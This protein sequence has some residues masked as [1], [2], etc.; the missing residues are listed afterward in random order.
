MRSLHRLQNT[1][2]ELV[3]AM[4]T[5]WPEV[6]RSS[7]DISDEHLSLART[8]LV[9]LLNW[10]DSFSN[11]LGNILRTFYR[12]GSDP[13]THGTVKDLGLELMERLQDESFTNVCINEGKGK[14]VTLVIT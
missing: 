7:P 4:V 3:V 6:L 2:S 8:L 9:V 11:D 12:W 13:V 10:A 5:V 14:Q 1:A